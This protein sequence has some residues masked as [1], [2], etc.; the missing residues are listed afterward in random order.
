MHVALVATE[1][2][3]NLSGTLD[4]HPGLNFLWGRN[5]QGK[6]S[7]IEALYVLGG[8]KSFRTHLSNELMA[9]NG[10]SA[11]LRAEVVRKNRPATLEIHLEDRQKTLFLNGKRVSVGEYLGHLDAF[12]YCHEEMC[13][14]RGEP[15]ERRR[16][17]DR[18]VVSL[19]PGFVQTIAD[20]NRVL[21][22]K[23]ALLR[24]ASDSE[25]RPSHLL[26][27]LDAWN[28]QL[29]IL[30]TALHRERMHYVAQLNQALQARLFGAETVTV[31]YASTLLKDEAGQARDEGG[32]GRDEGGGMRDETEFREVFAR[33]LSLRRDAEL[34]SGHALVGPH[35]DDLSI[36]A[37]GREVSRFGS[38]G[39]QRS[40]LLVL[41]L[42]QLEIYRATHDEYPVFLLDDLDAELDFGRIIALLD[43]LA[44]K[45]QVFVTTTKTG[46]V[47]ERR[48]RSVLNQIQGGRAVAAPYAESASRGI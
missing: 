35:R 5:G 7:W 29:L 12:V 40:A 47:E 28:E 3:R 34:A 13:I 30:G 15:S 32:Q 42:S 27:S 24:S 17:L 11:H 25:S 14:V 2:F 23:N 19:K 6:T 20:Y 26:D 37:D 43:Y 21:K 45:A 39:Q 8:T 31:R 46:L 38:A 9:F 33:K 1:G 36:A 4:G 44:D 16:F 48:H 41:T 22:Q 18:G 10:R